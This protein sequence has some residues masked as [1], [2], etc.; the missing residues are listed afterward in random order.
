MI[1]G[2]KNMCAATLCMALLP[3]IVHAQAAPRALT[4]DQIDRNS[5]AGPIAGQSTFEGDYRQWSEARD[6]GQILSQHAFQERVGNLLE[7]QAQSMGAAMQGVN[8]INKVSGILDAAHM[9]PGLGSAVGMF[10]QGFGMYSSGTLNL[11]TVASLIPGPTGMIARTVLSFLPSKFKQVHFGPN[12]SALAG[13]P[14]AD[15]EQPLLNE[16]RIGRLT[17]YTIS[18][19]N[20]RID[21]PLGDTAILVLPDEGKIYR[22]DLLAKTYVPYAIGRGANPLAFL[23]GGV[24]PS[25]AD[26][27]V[28]DTIDGSAAGSGETA[29]VA[30]RHFDVDEQ[31]SIEPVD[32]ACADMG[33]NVTMHR[34][35]DVAGIDGPP[36]LPFYPFDAP[37]SG[38]CTSVAYSASGS[39]A[40]AG[41]LVMRSRAEMRSGQYTFVTLTE[42]GNVAEPSADAVRSLFTVPKDF[43]ASL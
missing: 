6:K 16:Q 35:D 43:S 30:T 39:A 5:L 38:P 7:K 11:T 15:L 24:Q 20:V 10:S 8:A 28:T 4:F 3:A 26:L 22:L 42:R 31:L 18:G 23:T 17:H 27:R 12:A 14:I 33:S 36:V 19:E 41:H 40:N 21:D 29:G 37:L 9:L 2:L 1:R 25:H 13:V 32:T 34:S